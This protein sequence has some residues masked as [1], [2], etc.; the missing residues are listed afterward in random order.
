M[1]NPFQMLAE[2]FG[3]GQDRRPTSKVR[4]ADPRLE[5][6]QKQREADATAARQGLKG[7]A[8]RQYNLAADQTRREAGQAQKGVREG[9]SARGLLYSGQTIGKQAG[10]QAGAAQNLAM[11]RALANRAAEERA[12]SLEGEAV[13][14]SLDIQGLNQAALDARYENEM[15]RSGADSG[16]ALGKLGTIAGA[17]IGYAAANPKFSQSLGLSEAPKASAQEQY[18]QALLNKMGGK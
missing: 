13:Q 12:R 1:A 8:D 5:E 11:Q 14:G 6:L 9:Q 18:Y 15:Q 2:G 7:Y 10:I 16:G 4:G 3:F 17:G